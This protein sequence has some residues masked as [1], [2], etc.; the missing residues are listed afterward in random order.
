MEGK[1]CKRGCDNAAEEGS[2]Y[3]RPCNRPYVQKQ[4]SEFERRVQPHLRYDG[5]WGDV[6]KAYE[7]D[8]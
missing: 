8:R 5:Y 2:K 6:T 4:A 7:E 1:C 3:C